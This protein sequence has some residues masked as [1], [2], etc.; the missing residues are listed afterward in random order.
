MMMRP[1]PYFRRWCPRG[2]RESFCTTWQE[3]AWDTRRATVKGGH[4]AYLERIVREDHR[5][6]VAHAVDPIVGERVPLEV[7]ILR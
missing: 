6:R 4:E 1:E 7:E 2:E 5:Q 3:P